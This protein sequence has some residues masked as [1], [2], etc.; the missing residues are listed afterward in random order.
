MVG[1]DMS[2]L[3]TIILILVAASCSTSP[4]A[5]N[6]DISKP[7]YLLC[8][9]MLLNIVSNIYED[10]NLYWKMKYSEGKFVSTKT[11]LS[12]CWGL[13]TRQPLWVILCRLPEKGR[14]EIEEI[15]EERK[16]RNREERKTGMNV[17]KQKK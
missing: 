13:T 15:V 17:K 3:I 12:A 10:T 2:H 9:L 6:K 5:N 11:I 1:W 4:Y 16:E 7:E 14:K 8:S